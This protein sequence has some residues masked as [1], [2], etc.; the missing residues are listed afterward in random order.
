MNIPINTR[1]PIIA[2]Q[3]IKINVPAVQVW[4]V[5]TDINNWPGW[6][7]S[8]KKAH[9]KTALKE[10]AEFV[11]KAGRFPLKSKIH[12]CEPFD[13]FGWTGKTIG[14][15]AIHNWIFESVSDGTIVTAEESLQGFLPFI[16]RKK[17]KKTLAESMTRNLKELKDASEK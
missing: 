14:A 5:I 13:K 12:T 15:F 16:F 4:A 2:R 10:G 8:V 3:E 11:W 7:S 17:F 9:L 6:Q 1:A